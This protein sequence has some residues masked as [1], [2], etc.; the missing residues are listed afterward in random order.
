MRHG[1]LAQIA[2]LAGAAGSALVILPSARRVALLAGFALLAA[3]EVMLAIALVPSDDL[4]RLASAAGAGALVAAVL[5]AGAGATAL[6][7]FPA[8]TPLAVLIAA[9]FRLPVDLG[10]QHAFLLLP[11]Y[12]VLAAATLALLYRA[13]RGVALPRIAPLL[14]VPAAALIGWFSLSLLWAVDLEQGS[15]ELLF[16]LFPFAAL[17]AVVARSPVPGWLPRQFGV[18][19]VS[20]ASVFALIGLYQAWTHTLLFAQD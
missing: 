1:D 12:M 2:A 9:P 16:F 5:I 13:A 20:L 4:E 10:S 18:A 15:I 17:L 11:L 3:A 7:R 19:L 14:A 6:V 8:L